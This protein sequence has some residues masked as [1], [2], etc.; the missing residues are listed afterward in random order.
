ML[1]GFDHTLA[2]HG[3][4]PAVAALVLDRRMLLDRQVFDDLLCLHRKGL[5]DC[6]R[7]SGLV[8]FDG[9]RVAVLAAGGGGM[10]DFGLGDP[11]FL[12]VYQLI[13]LAAVLV[14]VAACKFCVNT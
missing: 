8:D 11:C 14:I 2:R 1:F 4:H 3:C 9:R 7:D 6:Q 12:A 13:C 10:Y 5:S